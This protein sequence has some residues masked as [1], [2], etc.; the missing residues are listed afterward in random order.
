MDRKEEK[1]IDARVKSL[2]ENVVNDLRREIVAEKE[3]AARRSGMKKYEQIS[4]LNEKL[5]ALGK[6]LAFGETVPL[7]GFTDRREALEAMIEAVET[8]IHFNMR[9][10]GLNYIK[11]AEMLAAALRRKLEEIRRR[12]GLRL[13]R[14]E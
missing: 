1:H 13:H 6:A 8:D 5:V 12:P 11:A 2:Y 10:R 4:D 3:E 9:G 7:D 14:T